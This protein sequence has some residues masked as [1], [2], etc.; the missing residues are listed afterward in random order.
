ML[1]ILGLLFLKHWW[2]DF[3]HQTPEHIKYKG[4]YGHRKG[5][6]HSAWHGALTALIFLI[7][8]PLDIALWLGLADF[9]LHYH[10]DYVKI[11]HGEADISKKEFWNH[12]GLDQLAHQIT[13][14]LLTSIAIAI[15]T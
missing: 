3:V 5:I 7:V 12:F 4:I 13:Y 9:L 6:E 2:V 15:G 8:C 14:I 10:I 1:S 11:K